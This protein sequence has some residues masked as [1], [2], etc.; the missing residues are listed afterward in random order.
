MSAC[1]L[2]FVRFLALCAISLL[3]PA[4]PAADAPKRTNVLY[5][6][7]D[8]QIA[9]APPAPK[10][11]AAQRPPTPTPP[12]KDTPKN[13]SPPV[14]SSPTPHNICESPPGQALPPAPT[15]TPPP[16]DNPPPPPANLLYPINEPD[17]M[18]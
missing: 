15:A 11:P 7:T 16:P 5:I 2:T 14:P 12:H 1:E 6:M 13:P 17:T 18:R 4:L 8:Q 3:A 9:S 10:T